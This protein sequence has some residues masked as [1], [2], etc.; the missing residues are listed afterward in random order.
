[1]PESVREPGADIRDV[2]ELGNSS[3]WRAFPSMS[4]HPEIMK[5][6]RVSAKKL[7]RKGG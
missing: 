4:L 7:K 2:K 5:E 6:C 1:M 3:E